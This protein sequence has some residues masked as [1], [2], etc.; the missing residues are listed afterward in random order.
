M[1]Y[2]PSPYLRTVVL[3]TVACLAT[4]TGFACND[5][6]SL[7]R[8]PIPVRTNRLAS[9][10]REVC[11]V[12]TDGTAKCWGERGARRLTLPDGR[13]FIR[14]SGGI[15]HLC[16]LANDSTAWCWGR[17]ATGQLGNGLTTGGLLPE[18]VQ[19]VVKFIA[20]GAA[21]Y[22]SC[23]LDA[24]GLL[25]C[26]GGN[27][28]GEL[29][30][31]RSSEQEIVLSPTRARSHVQ[32]RDLQG[33]CAVSLSQRLYC[34]ISTDG[35]LSTSSPHTEPGNC[36]GI[37]YSHFLGTDCLT[38]TPVPAPT[39]V[40]KGGGCLLDVH[41]DVYCFGSSGERGELGDGRAGIG[42]FA[43]VPV[44]VS[45]G[46]KYRDISARCALDF[47]GIAYCWG[48]NA[49]GKLGNGGGANRAEP[50][51][52]LT[53]ERFVEIASNLN[54]C[55]LTATDDVWCWGPN[56]FGINGPTATGDRSPVPVR[57]E[58]PPL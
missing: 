35:I 24:V 10:G 51:P 4:F 43:I 52:V 18:R 49:F 3:R 54:T 27:A 31:G 15:D 29:A 38:P 14:L 45:G 48:S 7:S 21:S 23:G 50:T 28:R 30:N 20:V 19:T 55:A 8:D 13:R 39:L 46:R 44:R 11:L 17:A 58:L 32:F 33:N 25:Y 57:V 47:E 1:I 26:W 37:Y 12:Q 34:W 53:D 56:V 22:A 6:V 2:A 9:S 40:S 16:G 36:R 5:P 41:A 42:V